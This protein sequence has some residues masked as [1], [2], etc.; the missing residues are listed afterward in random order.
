MPLGGELGCGS[1][2]RLCAS[3][4]GLILLTTL[5]EQECGKILRRLNAEADES[6]KFSYPTMVERIVGFRRAGHATGEAGFG[7][8]GRLTTVL[9]PP[10]LAPRPLA[11]GVVFPEASSMD[12][13]ALVST[14][15]SGIAQCTGQKV[16]D[17]PQAAPALV[18]A[19]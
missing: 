10:S 14:M 15:H 2:E 18:R 11:L 7:C 1:S 6:T 12:P 3:V 8:D 16:A 13:E 9:V 19:V 4:A 17:G 5:T